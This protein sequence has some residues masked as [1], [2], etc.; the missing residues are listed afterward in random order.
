ME[1]LTNLFEKYSTDSVFKDRFTLTPE[2]V[3]DEMPGRE[4]EQTRMVEA[5]SI[6]LDPFRPVAVNIAIIGPA[7]V[8]KTTLAKRITKDLKSYAESLNINL[9]TQYVN[10]HSFRTKTSILRRLV[11]DGFTNV[12]GRGFSDEEMMEMLAKKLSRENKRIVLTIDEAGMLRGE[13]ILGLI[14]MNELFPP[15]EGRVSIIIITRRQQWSLML[16]THLSGRVQDQINMPKYTREQLETILRYRAQLGFYAG[17]ISDEVLDM[18]VDIAATTGNARHGIE[19]M[20]RCGMIANAK[21]SSIITPEFVRAAKN[22]VYPE[23]RPDVFNDLKINE[24][25]VALSIATILSKGGGVV[26]TTI[27]EAYQVYKMY[28]ETYQLKG[29]SKATFRIYLD[30]L[31]QLGIVVT[32]VKPM[33]DGSRGRR[34]IIT[35]HDIPA[36]IVKER[37]EEAIKKKI[38]A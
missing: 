3:P 38:R 25:V 17:V 2:F 13:D 26:Q 23:L 29:Q 15:G 6:L 34:S 27:N 5:L 4:D 31:A 1:V 9:D 36:I 19:I 16:N 32:Q 35:L 12:Q 8:G 37:V 14:H 18:I 20:L 21:K 33:P 30:N 11:T 22:E 24:L 7:G 28:C 10:C